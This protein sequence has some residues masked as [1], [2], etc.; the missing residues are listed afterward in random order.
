VT[1]V[2]TCALPIYKNQAK[3][4]KPQ[5]LLKEKPE[6]NQWKLN[7]HIKNRLL[8]IKRNKN[9]QTKAMMNKEN[10]KYVF[11]DFLSQLTIMISDN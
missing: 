10:S 6:N 9:H 2:Q 1:G 4:K 8:I 7:H 5:L 11:K 3:K